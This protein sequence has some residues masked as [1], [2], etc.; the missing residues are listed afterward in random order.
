MPEARFRKKKVVV[1]HKLTTHAKAL[2][3]QASF[4]TIFFVTIVASHTSAGRFCLHSSGLWFAHE[5]CTGCTLMAITLNYTKRFRHSCRSF[6][7]Q[8]QILIIFHLSSRHYLISS[9]ISY[10]YQIFCHNTVKL[11]L[12]VCSTYIHAHGFARLSLSVPRSRGQSLRAA[13]QTSVFLSSTGNRSSW[14][15]SEDS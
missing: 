10:Q 6:H 12:Y 13:L 14:L 9:Y 15:L 7:S 5:V 1:E 2:P 4:S 3:S 11:A 8:W